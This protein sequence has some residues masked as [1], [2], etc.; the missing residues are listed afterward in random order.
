MWAPVDGSADAR[1]AE[2]LPMERVSLGLLVPLALQFKC[3]P[4]VGTIAI[5]AAATSEFVQREELPQAAD[6][7]LA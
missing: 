4:I 2:L 5:S 3:G 7:L 1:I 6:G